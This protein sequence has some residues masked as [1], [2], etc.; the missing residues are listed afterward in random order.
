MAEYVTLQMNWPVHVVEDSS[1]IKQ[2]VFYRCEDQGYIGEF[3]LN[4]S[5][6]QEF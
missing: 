2:Q 4:D 3:T 6:A 1:S 5:P